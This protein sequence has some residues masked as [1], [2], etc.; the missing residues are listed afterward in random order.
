MRQRVGIAPRSEGV[1]VGQVVSWGKGL[2]GSQGAAP[3]QEEKRGSYGPALPPGNGAAGGAGAPG[4]VQG[5]SPAV[6]RRRPVPVAGA[7]GVVMGKE[8][9]DAGAS[10]LRCFGT[11]RSR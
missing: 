5:G 9:C 1:R 10:G 2:R 3:Q 6:L 8:V 7:S 4:S 11:R